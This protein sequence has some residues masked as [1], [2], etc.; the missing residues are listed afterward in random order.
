LK[1][2]PGKTEGSTEG[3][4]GIKHDIFESH[5]EEGNL[6]KIILQPIHDLGKKLGERGRL[7]SR[8][9]G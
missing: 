5:I 7:G 2:Q 8:D 9:E 4:S 1:E 3:N 6:I